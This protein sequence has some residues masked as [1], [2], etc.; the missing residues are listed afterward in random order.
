MYNSFANWINPILAENYF[1][2]VEAFNFNLYED[3]ENG[4]VVFSVQLIGAPSYDADD[5]DWACEEIF[6]TG[7]NL[8][9]LPD[10]N[11][12][13]VCL[14]DFKKIIEEYLKKGEYA[15]TLMC[16]KAVAYGFVDGDLEIA[17][18]A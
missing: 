15:N 9:R 6:S 14:Q 5:S 18:E 10:C 13:E 17:Y 1:E 11:D 3:C 8:F 2:G 16:T 7:E 4:E 12:W